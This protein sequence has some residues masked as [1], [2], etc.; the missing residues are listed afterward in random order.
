MPVWPVDWVHAGPQR[1]PENERKCSAAL[2]AIY[3]EVLCLL[4]ILKNEVIF[5]M[6]FILLFSSFIFTVFCTS[7]DPQQIGKGIKGLVHC[8]RES[9]KQCARQLHQDF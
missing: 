8:P 1:D 5:Q 9:E 2:A 7:I 4:N 6:L 3:R